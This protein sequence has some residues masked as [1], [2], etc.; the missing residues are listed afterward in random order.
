[1]LP[2]APRLT[3]VS[4]AA[5]RPAPVLE[6]PP[7]RS[8]RLLGQVRERLRMLHYSLRTEEAYLHWCKA[9]IRFHQ[10]R[11]PAEMGG[12]EVEAFLTHLTADRGLSVSSHRQAL[13]A[14]LFLYGKVLGQ[15][16]PWMQEIGRPVPRRRLPVVLTPDEV[17]A[18]LG[19]MTGVHGL[20][21]RLLY[22]TGMRIT[23]GLRL[24]VK[25][26][27]FGQR[28]VIVREGKGGKDRV[29]MLPLSLV[30]PLRE[31]LTGVRAVWAS[32]VEAGRSGVELPSALD[33]KY[34]RAAH[35]W[36]WFWVFP[37]GQHSTDPRSGVVRRHHLFDETF[38]LAFKRAVTA[39]G[40][41][42][43]ASP[44]TEPGLRPS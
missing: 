12:P 19:R 4:R 32:D 11:H 36:S 33:R 39:A 21:A 16:L 28:A 22:G 7:L 35:A 9:F 24:R 3:P 23:E 25:D 42:K 6:L 14:L 31:H 44:H 40:V 15:Q 27:D 41:P 30:Q 8:V 2:S 10:L 20:L 43:L 18:V 37:Q 29:V 38:Q 5:L 13:S 17:A 26:I 1:M 34:P